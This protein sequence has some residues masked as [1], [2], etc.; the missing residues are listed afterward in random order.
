MVDWEITAK[1]I[2]CD[3]VEDEVTIM[4]YKDGSLRCTG[5]KKYTVPNRVTQR[6]M[7]QKSAELKKPIKCE[8]EGCYRAVGY[9]DRIMT[10]ESTKTNG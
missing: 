2:Y 9:K 5:F 8:G 7:K 1:T 3:A 6:V 10:E 4:L